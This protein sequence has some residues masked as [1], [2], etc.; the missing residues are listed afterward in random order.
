MDEERL[1]LLARIASLYYEDELTQNEISARL[2]YSRSCISR[3]LSEA[4]REGIV[5]IQVHHPLERMRALE[6]AL[7]ERFDLRD[8]RVFQSNGCAYPQML[9]RLGTLA[10]RLLEEKIRE[11]S[12]LGIS[13]GTALY[14]VVHALRPRY[15]PQVKVVQLIGSTSTEDHQVDGPGLARALARAFEGRY[16]TLPAPWLVE[17]RNL[18]D[19]LMNDRRLREVLDLA[20][21]VDIAVLGVGTT[22]PS[23]SSFFRAGYLT[24]EETRALLAMGIVGD[25]CGQ[26]FTLEGTVLDIPVA[27][28]VFGVSVETL[29]SIPCAVG[30][31]GGL[32]KSPAILGA[33]RS[34]MI[35]TLVTDDSAARE[36]LRLSSA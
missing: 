36:A 6:R 1:E 2:G 17:D 10:A 26:H 14:E 29:R 11:D 3:L 16:Y 7:Q 8:V 4:R 13:W 31:A 9:A 5:E 25:V 15:A 32:A 35:N 20:E 18:R 12:V 27:G 24:L 23:L 34:R 19:A 30:V 22:D 28:Y 21:Q 33:L